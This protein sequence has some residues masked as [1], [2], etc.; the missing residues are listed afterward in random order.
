MYFFKDFHIRRTKFVPSDLLRQNPANVVMFKELRHS[1]DDFGVEK[2]EADCDIGIFVHDLR[3]D[4]ARSDGDA[5][6]LAA[7]ADQGFLRRFAGLDFA[8][9]KLP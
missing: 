6:L 8:A 1:A 2:G 4:A 3:K 9:D 5:K 7:F